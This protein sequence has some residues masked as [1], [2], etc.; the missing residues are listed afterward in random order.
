VQR[1]YRLVRHLARASTETL[2]N[3]VVMRSHMDFYRDIDAY[4][5]KRKM[6]MDFFDVLLYAQ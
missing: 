5:E 1:S 6:F 4:H 2:L 3:P